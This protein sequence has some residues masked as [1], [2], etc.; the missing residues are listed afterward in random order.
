MHSKHLTDRP[1]GAVP[2]G[3]TKMFDIVIRPAIVC[4][5]FFMCFDGAAWSTAATVAMT[6]APTIVPVTQGRAR[7]A[8]RAVT[9]AEA[10]ATATVQLG[11][12]G[13]GRCPH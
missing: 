3:V 2:F 7:E 5:G 1:V 10:M 13:L 8:A 9:R 11:H 6:E 4:S 12:T